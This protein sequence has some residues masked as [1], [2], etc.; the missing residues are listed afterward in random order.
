MPAG[1]SEAYLGAMLSRIA[2]APFGELFTALSAAL[3]VL[4]RNQGLALASVVGPARGG[5]G[6]EVHVEAQTNALSATSLLAELGEQ[7]R[8]RL[9]TELSWP[10]PCVIDADNPPAELLDLA[11]SLRARDLKSAAIAELV[12]DGQ[13]IAWLIVASR[14]RKLLEERWSSELSLIVDLLALA[15]ARYDVQAALKRSNSATAGHD[16]PT[17]GVTQ[18]L[19]EPMTEAALRALERDNLRLALE[20]CGWKVQGPHGAARLLGL[21]PSTLR[22]RMRSFGLTRPQELGPSSQRSR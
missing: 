21:S 15:L 18:K 14:G 9:R 20:R 17:S 16:A 7:G 12:V 11:H 4:C 1:D 13:P 8:L 19:A 6:L 3:E 22:D 10:T 5:A 2:R